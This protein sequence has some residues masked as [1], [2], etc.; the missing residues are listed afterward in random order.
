MIDGETQA[1]ERHFLTRTASDLKQ[2]TSD[3]FP[4]TESADRILAATTQIVTAWLAANSVASAA[5]PGLIRDIHRTLTG[6]EPDHASEV[7]KEVR[8]AKP[9][10]GP[11]A[12]IEARKSVFADHLV[13]LED[14]KHV[15][16]LKRHL[17]TAHGL[18]PELYRKKWDLPATYPMVAPNYAKVRSR[19]AKESGLGK[20][21]RPGI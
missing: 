19:L 4:M 7:P 8:S 13:C 9:Q 3:E 14:G 1:T 5:L 2:P 21:G 20:G 18:T 16:M 10:P 12:A 15:T 6:L 17:A 11:R